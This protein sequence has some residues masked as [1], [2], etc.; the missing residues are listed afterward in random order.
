MNRK[1]L[2]LGFADTFSTAVN[3]FTEA[4]SKRFHI[5]RD[6][7]NP[8][9]LIYGEGVYGQ[10]HRRFGPEVT[11]IFYTGENVRPPWGECQYA[12]TFDHENSAKHYR[13]PLYVIDMWGA[14]T[15][16][17]TKDYYQLVGLKHD[18]EREYDE[19]DF[20]SFVVSNPGQDMRNK[21]FHFINEYK[22]V[23][24]GGPHLNNI[25]HVLPRDKLLHKLNFLDCYRFNICFENGSH[26]GYV[27]EKLFN[28]LQIKTMPIYWGSATVDRDFNPLAFI[29]AADHGN[30]NKLVDY[31]QH[32]D[33]PSGKQEYL[34]I[35]ERPAFK[36]DVPNEFTDMNNLC[37]WWET[38][39]MGE[40]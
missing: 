3:F 33:S 39:V 30:F 14:V 11:K 10:N 6:D 4:L 1:P 23:D 17:W 15:E 34:D 32:L 12:M 5:I 22:T 18:Y 37:E 38:F 35:I 13:L 24:S 40:K 2:K 25:G 28:A 26:P 9:F 8:E 20:C 27:T 29:N 36:N 21:A 31:V 7:A 19:R 16:G